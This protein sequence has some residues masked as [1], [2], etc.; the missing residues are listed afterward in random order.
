MAVYELTYQFAQSLLGETASA[1][2]VGSVFC[3]YAGYIMLGA[4]IYGTFKFLKYLLYAFK[5]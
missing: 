3:Q 2:A 1:T 4:I 5:I